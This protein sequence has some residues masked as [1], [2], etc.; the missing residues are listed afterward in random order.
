MMIVHHHWMWKK[1]ICVS[2][3]KGQWVILPSIGFVDCSD[4]WRISM[5]VLNWAISILIKSNMPEFQYTEQVKKNGKIV[6]SRVE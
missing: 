6:W 3:Y 1:R 4:G 5:V 2:R